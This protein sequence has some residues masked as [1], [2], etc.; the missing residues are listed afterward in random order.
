MDWADLARRQ[1]GVIGRGQLIALGWGE[2][3]VARALS[4]GTLTQSV[5]GVFLV[6]GAPFT[7]EAELWT[8]IVSTGGVL[9]F[10]TA[11]ALWEMDERPPLIH[12]IV[13]TDRRVARRAT[14]RRHHV[15]TPRS[16]ITE[17]AG[18]PVTTQ[19]WT[20]IDHLGRLPFSQ[21]MRLA[22]RG[23]QRGW[24]TRQDMDRRLRDYP[25]RQG[26]AMIRRLF[27][28][29]A[30]GAAAESERLLHRLLRAAGL[31]R[32]RANY[33]VVSGGRIVAVV[34]IAFVAARVAIELDGFAYHSDVDRFRRDRKR[35]NALVA[36]GWTVL[37][38]TWD[39]L[40]NRPDEI[41]AEIVEILNDP[42]RQ[43][44]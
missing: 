13:G 18:M 8:A 10:A 26:N 28:A 24:I 37:R 35:Q 36:L 43:A 7:Y 34:D 23:L 14:L 21:G 20:L 4:I 16:A 6:R 25:G 39:D 19:G 17:I 42:G 15:F 12:V 29:S 31:R 3:R 2:R 44:S 5:T 11:A 1:A 30:D 9:G 38:Y 32:W 33:R 41:V 27:E 40:K 22:D